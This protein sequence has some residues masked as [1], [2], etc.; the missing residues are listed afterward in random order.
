MNTK[1]ETEIVKT[2]ELNKV[3]FNVFSV[4]YIASCFYLFGYDKEKQNIYL[5]YFSLFC[6]IVGGYFLFFNNFIKPKIIGFLKIS[7]EEIE[8]EEGDT[9]KTIPYEDIE[10]IYLKYMGY[11]SWWS[12]SIYG[13]KNYITITEK[14]GD[15]YDF[16][17]L[18]R[19]EKSKNNLKIIFDNPKFY[20]KFD[21]V[22]IGNNNTMK[23]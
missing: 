21:V 22:N 18:I 23:F 2:K 12:H 15:K 4:L 10:E 17:I 16:E 19:D 13:N 1:F 11:G 8:I 9:N 6:L 7:T 5:K 14:S 20:D 3:I